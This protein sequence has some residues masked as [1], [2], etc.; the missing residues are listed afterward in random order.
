MQNPIQS[1]KRVPEIQG[2]FGSIA[3][4]HSGCCMFNGDCGFHLNSFNEL[5]LTAFL[6]D[7]LAS[8][9]FCFPVWNRE[10]KEVKWLPQ[11][12]QDRQWQIQAPNPL[13]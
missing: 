11:S 2:D 13:F 8:F 6:W 12:P 3:L 4:V 1:T 10:I 5:G 9:R 7:G